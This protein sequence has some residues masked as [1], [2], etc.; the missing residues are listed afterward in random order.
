MAEIAGLFYLIHARMF[1][2]GR[3]GTAQQQVR[4]ADCADG[5]VSARSLAPSVAA[6]IRAPQRAC[7]ATGS[8]PA[9]RAR[10]CKI[11]SIGVGVL[12]GS[13]LLL[14]AAGKERA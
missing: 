2:R 11:V 13:F 8:A 1:G 10:S 6:T 3:A 9:V 4:G 7:C 5:R 12:R 14:D